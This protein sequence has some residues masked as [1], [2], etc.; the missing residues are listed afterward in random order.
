MGV[1]PQKGLLLSKIYETHFINTKENEREATS[2]KKRRL[3]LQHG[4]TT[5]SKIYNRKTRI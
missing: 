3:V 5:P 1:K 2:K 4:P